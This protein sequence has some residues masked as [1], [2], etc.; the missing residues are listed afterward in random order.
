MSVEEKYRTKCHVT[1]TRITYIFF[2]AHI[3]TGICM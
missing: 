3:N 1:D 2:Q